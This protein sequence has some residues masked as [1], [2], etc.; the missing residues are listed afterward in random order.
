MIT[1]DAVYQCVQRHSPA[2]VSLQ[3]ILREL[4]PEKKEGSMDWKVEAV[5]VTRLLN[6]LVSEFKIT[7]TESTDEVRWRIG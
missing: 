2:G 4:A 5:M 6:G 1:M 7:T 3:Q